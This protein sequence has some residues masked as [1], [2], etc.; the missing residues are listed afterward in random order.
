M[1]CGPL[2]AYGNAK[3]DCEHQ[4]YKQI[5]ID[6]GDPDYWLDPSVVEREIRQKGKVIFIIGPHAM[7]VMKLLTNSWTQLHKP[8]K[9]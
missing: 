9:Q 8:K 1:R 4:E 5:C 7:W 6:A 2:P 3:A